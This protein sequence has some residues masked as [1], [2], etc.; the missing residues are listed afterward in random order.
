MKETNEVQEPSELRFLQQLALLEVRL[1]QVSERLNALE[2]KLQP[3]LGPRI[4]VET[5]P[6][7]GSW[8]DFPLV[9]ARLQTA[10]DFVDQIAD[11]LRALYLRA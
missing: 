7:K 11:Q 10:A 2:S 8:D 4:L 1:E 6:S 3:I 9:S 5:V